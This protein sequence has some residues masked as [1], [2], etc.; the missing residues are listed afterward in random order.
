[1]NEVII[2]YIALE[3]FK[4]EDARIIVD[5]G[6]MISVSDWESLSP[7]HEQGKFEP[8]T[9]GPVTEEASRT[10]ESLSAHLEGVVKFNDKLSW[11]GTKTAHKELKRL[12]DLV[13]MGYR[14]MEQE[15]T[16]E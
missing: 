14:L 16:A 13:E 15:K 3:R 7:M 1:M 6:D 5:E 4:S 8:L 11:N 9:L 12:M 10:A 2:V